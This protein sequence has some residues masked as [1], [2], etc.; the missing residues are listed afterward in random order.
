MGEIDL[1]I[2]ITIWAYSFIFA[3]FSGVFMG[4]INNSKREDLIYGILFWVNMIL[5]VI[6]GYILFEYYFPKR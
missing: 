6:S 4:C 1:L 3:I 2:F 5:F